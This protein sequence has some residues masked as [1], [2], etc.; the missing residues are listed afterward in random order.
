MFGKNIFFDGDSMKTYDKIAAPHPT[1]LVKKT[2][3]VAFLGDSVTQGCFEVYKNG[4]NSV[5]TVYEAKSAYSAKFKEFL[6]LLYPDM[7]IHTIN[8]G[9]SGDNSE[10]GLNR[11]DED[12]LKYRPDLVV[13]SYGLNDAG[14][15][16]AA[17]VGD[18]AARIKSIFIKAKN[19]G[20]DVLYLTQNYMTNELSVRITDP[21][22]KE[23]ANGCVKIQNEKILKKY[24]EAGKAVA[25]EEGVAVVD[26]YA[27]WESLERANV[28]VTE[29]LAN[30]I[31]HPV[32][33]Y[34]AYIAIKI[35]EKI[36][37]IKA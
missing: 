7:I 13:V 27:V 26:G 24:F 1:G 21:F 11:M 28:E 10:N 4:E 3:T 23:I 17:G 8:A 22:I 33:E 2:I 32:R 19:S 35:I 9:I 5:E 18:Y 36:L 31:N 12:V 29:L 15:F 14:T 16:G 25:E 6:N 20:A 30:R 37:G 34:H